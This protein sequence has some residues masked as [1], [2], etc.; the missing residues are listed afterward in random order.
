MEKVKNGLFVSVHYKGTLANGE[1]F[2]T[3][4]GQNPLE[5][6][7]GAG[8]LIKGFESALMDMS[9]NEKKTFT[10]S[11]EDAYGN[12]NDDHK[13]AFPRK[14]IPSGMDPQVGQTIGLTTPDG[15][16]IPAHITEVDDEK[17]VVDLNH[18]LAGES[19]TFDIEVVGISE[20]QTQESGGCGCGDSGCGSDS[21]DCGQESGG[22]GSDGCNC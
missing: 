6:K 11:P 14:D 4:E 19:L 7:M 20:V 16:Q 8:Q 3:S 9:L 22:C 10:L 2:D 12:R 21:G 17:V 13:Q 1:V 15:Q 18:P 5:I